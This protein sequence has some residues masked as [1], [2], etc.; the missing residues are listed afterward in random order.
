MLGV[1]LLLLI[2]SKISYISLRRDIDKLLEENGFVDKYRM[3]LANRLGSGN[4]IE[5]RVTSIGVLNWIRKNIWSFIP[6]MHLIPIVAFFVRHGFYENKEENFYHDWVN[7]VINIG[8]A[9]KCSKEEMEGICTIE[10]EITNLKKEKVRELLEKIGMVISVEETT[11]E[12][13]KKSE[14][15]EAEEEAI[16]NSSIETNT[17]ESTEDNKNKQSDNFKQE[18]ESE[19]LEQFL[20]ELEEMFDATDKK[21]NSAMGQVD[22]AMDDLDKELEKI[23]KL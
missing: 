8:F 11:S 23:L 17:K 2:T 22:Q 16:P 14:K 9:Q 20:K 4:N 13:E 3:E 19:V 18:V 1:Y 6:I 21:I 15:L 7:F 12:D 5:Y 10:K